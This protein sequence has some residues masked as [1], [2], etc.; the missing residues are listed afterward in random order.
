M[1]IQHQFPLY[2]SL[3]LLFLATI[4]TLV[5][6][7]LGALGK[8]HPS[9]YKALMNIK[10]SLNNPYH[11][12]SWK[13][14]TDCC[15]W[16]VVKCDR[17]T[18]R[19]NELT[20]FQG[21][22]SGQIPS[23]VGDLPYLETITFRHLTNVTGTIPQSITKLKNLYSLD[24]TYLSL[25]GPVPNFLNQ[26]TKLKYLDLSFNQFSGSI[27]PNLSELKYL[28]A[29]H[30]DRNRLTGSIPESFGRFPGPVIPHLFLSHNQL[31]GPIPKS[32]GALD[33]GTIDL[34]RNRFTGDASMLFNAKH[35]LTSYIDL[36]RNQ[37]SFDLTN[38][39]FP[40][41]LTWL[42]LNHNKIFGRIPEE[43]KGLELQLLNV[44]YNSLCGKIPYGGKM[45]SFH[46]TDYFHNK[47]LCGSP[48]TA[49]K[50]PNA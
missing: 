8:C 26:L 27:P 1:K 6:P 39:K 30:L 40:K 5:S 44:S 34:S 3:F 45:Q 48:M 16:Y 22:I 38:V 21:E 18:N 4:T 47:C 17:K 36:S 7:S 9:D 14:N 20:V 25:S 13:P 10:K 33:Y 37:F 32:L 2:Y 46:S 28:E 42:D 19:I 41:S 50:K 12:A 43:I 31:S 11:L 35:S 23:S 29:I 49:C 24:L 15:E